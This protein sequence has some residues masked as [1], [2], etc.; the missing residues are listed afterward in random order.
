MQK[1]AKELTLHQFLR[2]ILHY[3]IQIIPQSPASSKMTYASSSTF[4]FNLPNSFPCYSHNA[5]YLF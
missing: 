5:S 3:L 4:T 2:L 1:K